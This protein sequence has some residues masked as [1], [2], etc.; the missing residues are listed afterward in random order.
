MRALAVVGVAFILLSAVPGLAETELKLTAGT[1]QLGG[2]ATGSFNTQSGPRFNRQREIVDDTITGFRLGIA[3]E[4]GYFVKDGLV[5]LGGAQYSDGFG[6]LYRDTAAL[7]TFFAGA[8]YYL[9]RGWLATPYGGADFGMGF[10]IPFASDDD[11]SKALQLQ[12]HLG[13]L[14][15]LNERVA[16]DL[17]LRVTYAKSL[18][19]NGVDQLLVPFGYLGVQAF[20]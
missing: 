1:I 17:G 20:F 3:P 8:R 11:V 19:D 15:P 12:A 7:V 14:W 16:I 2:E 5:I 4:V 6:K 10:G 13:A 18:E 9:A